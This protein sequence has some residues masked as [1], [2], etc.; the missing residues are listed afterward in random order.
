MIECKYKN[1]EYFQKL[2]LL[3]FHLNV[4]SVKKHFNKFHILLNELNI[5]LDIIAIMYQVSGIMPYK[6]STP[7]PFY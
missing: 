7:K 2:F 4:C 3:L 6:Y 1:M 5:D